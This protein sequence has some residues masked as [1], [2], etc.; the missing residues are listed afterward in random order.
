MLDALGEAAGPQ[1][2]L[3]QIAL[4]NC[5]LIFAV[6]LP[7]GTLGLWLAQRCGLPGVYRPGDTLWPRYGQPLVLGVVVGLVLVIVDLAVQRLGF[8]ASFPHPPF[9]ASILASLS[10]GI[11]E[12]ILFRLFLMSLWVVIFRW[13]LGWVVGPPQAQAAAL[14]AANIL[15]ALPLL[16]PTWGR[17][18][19]WSAQARL[20]NCRR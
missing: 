10:A 9:P 20:R 2:P 15:A 12:E 8:G 5:L 6:Y 14:V 11:G 17:Q 3:W 1:L 18:W 16:R 13:L 4:A 19:C 7:L